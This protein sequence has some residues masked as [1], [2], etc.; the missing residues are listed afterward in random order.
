MYIYIYIYIYIKLKQRTP[1][2]VY[3]PYEVREEA[4]N[5]KNSQYVNLARNKNHDFVP[6]ALVAESLGGLR[7]AAIKLFAETLASS[8][9]SSRHPAYWTYLATI[10]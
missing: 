2:H 6:G 5:L 1:G 8:Q 9:A 7:K 10:N 3:V 4:E